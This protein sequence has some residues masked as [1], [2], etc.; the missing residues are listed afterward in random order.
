MKK[1]ITARAAQR[2]K[3]ARASRLRK[4]AA[5]PLIAST[6][7]RNN[8]FVNSKTESASYKL[9]VIPLQRNTNVQKNV[10]RNVA[11]I[12]A[13][14]LSPTTISKKDVDN[15]ALVCLNRYIRKEVLFAK[16]FYGKGK[17]RGRR[18]KP[19]TI[20]HRSKILC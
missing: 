9:P 13:S 16:D 19:K 5:I 14:A 8:S 12:I 7:I 1:V 18:F 20:T 4:F 11:P 10:A 15:P 6:P 3:K 2:T 17:G